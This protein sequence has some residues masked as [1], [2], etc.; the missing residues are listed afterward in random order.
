[1]Y[2]MAILKIILEIV[3]F[4]VFSSQK[5]YIIQVAAIHARNLYIFNFE[6]KSVE[7]SQKQFYPHPLLPYESIIL[8]ESFRIKHPFVGFWYT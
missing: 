6:P 1:M 3:C 4:F 7:C 5:N 8:C 2:K